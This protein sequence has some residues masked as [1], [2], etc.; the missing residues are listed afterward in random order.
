MTSI[1]K[2]VEDM[3]MSTAEKDGEIFGHPCK[4]ITIDPGDKVYCDFCNIDFTD[5][6]DTGGFLFGSKA[7]CPACEDEM[8]ST[9]EE[10]NEQHLIKAYCP[11]SYSFADWIR[12]MR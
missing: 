6:D 4:T 10:Y 3:G 11:K 9:I 7:V 8:L 1:K 5:R 12:T 2:I